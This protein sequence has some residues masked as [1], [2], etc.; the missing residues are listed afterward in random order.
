MPTAI[1]P[2]R[3][4]PSSPSLRPEMDLGI[5]TIGDG[6]FSAGSW[7]PTILLTSWC[8]VLF[9]VGLWVGDLWRTEGL[10]ALVAGEMLRSGD[11]IVPRVDGQPLFTKPPG[12]YIAI[13][14]CSL[15]FGGVTAATARLPSAL[16]ATATVFLFYWYF[17]RRLGT[18]AG[19]IAALLLPMAP[20]WLDKATAAEIDMLQVFWVTAALVCL[21]RALDEHDG[22]SGLPERDSATTGD[23]Y[24]VAP[25]PPRPGKWWLAALLCVAGGVLT[26]WTAPA[27]FYGAAIPLLWWR[28][29]LRLL[30]SRQHLLSAVIC[31]GVCLSWIVAAAWREG[32]DVLYNTVKTEAL[33][34]LVPGYQAGYPYRWHL[35]LLHPLRI[36]VNTLPWSIL[37][38]LTLQRG[39]SHCWDARGRRLLQELHCWAWP[40][41]LFWSLMSEHAPRHSFPLFPAIAGLAALVWIAVLSGRLRVAR[42]RVRPARLFVASL[43]VWLIVKTTFTFAVVPIRNAPRSPQDT[44]GSFAS[45][46]AADTLSVSDATGNPGAH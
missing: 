38:L 15:P 45:G 43:A 3:V 36:I 29:Q 8:G 4:S 41:L 18:R 37:A 5:W 46:A 12:M 9:F 2:P 13:V 34:R 42:V 33:A 28:G 39:F 27:F 35:A 21:F 26:K 20:M 10:R 7:W 25:S 14:L 6:W 17:Q 16:A 22:V 23:T 40:N 1:S 44:A 19:L 11:W 30:W 31:A 24:F 32:W